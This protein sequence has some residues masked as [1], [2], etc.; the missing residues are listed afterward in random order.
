MIKFHAGRRVLIRGHRLQTSSRSLQ[1]AKDIDSVLGSTGS[2]AKVHSGWQ[3]IINKITSARAVLLE[4]V[5]RE[6]GCTPG[7]RPG[8][9]GGVRT[10]R[11]LDRRY[12]SSFNSHYANTSAW[13]SSSLDRRIKKTPKS[14]PKAPAAPS[15][16]SKNKKLKKV[17]P[18]SKVQTKPKRA[19]K[20][21]RPANRPAQKPAS[22]T[23]RVAPLPAVRNKNA[24]LCNKG[25]ILTGDTS[26][27]R[28]RRQPGK[29][30]TVKKTTPK[31][32]PRIVPKPST[33]PKGKPRMRRRR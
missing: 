22:T 28:T 18:R 3:R 33:R 11:K 17:I 32:K 25:P 31:K 15:C 20:P 21:R 12:L 13:P 29:Q 27:T 26:Q 5:R 1:T 23:K 24:Q 9:G 7:P 30:A 16:P 4:D 14:G 19:T 10:R 2:R 8:A 6:I